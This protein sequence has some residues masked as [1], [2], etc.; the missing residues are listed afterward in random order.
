MI[1]RYLFLICLICSSVI[2][3]EQ[4]FTANRVRI[5]PLNGKYRVIIAYTHLELQEYQEAS[6]DFNTLKEAQDAF[7]KLKKGECFRIGGKVRPCKN[8]LDKY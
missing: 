7:E 3:A 1:F 6:L 2:F 5:V 4:V 8:T